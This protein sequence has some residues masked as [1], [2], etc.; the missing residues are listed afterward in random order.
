MRSRSLGDLAGKLTGCRG[1]RNLAK[2]AL[3]QRRLDHA[4]RIVG[5]HSCRHRSRQLAALVGLRGFA[6]QLRIRSAWTLAIVAKSGMGYAGPT[7]EAVLLR[8]MGIGTAAD[9]NG[10]SSPSTIQSSGSSAPDPGPSRSIS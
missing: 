7:Q 6:P 8:S 5:D 2:D 10:V 3:G 9:A 4:N 1:D